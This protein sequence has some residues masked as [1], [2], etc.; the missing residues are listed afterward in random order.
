[1][2]PVKL[3]AS[4]LDQDWCAS[5]KNQYQSEVISKTLIDGFGPLPTLTRNHLKSLLKI[6]VYLQQKD[7][8]RI[9]W[10]RSVVVDVL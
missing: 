9:P 5:R 10:L 4:G 7:R 8:R 2:T 1:M 6:V 3:P